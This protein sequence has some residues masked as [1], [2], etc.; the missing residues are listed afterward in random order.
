MPKLF[1]V[2]IVCITALLN[3]THSNAQ[4]R[5][6]LTV[7]YDDYPFNDACIPGDGFSCMITGIGQNL[8]FDTGGNAPVLL[9]NM[10]QL[11]MDPG[12]FDF[13]VI[14]HEHKDHTNGLLSIL[15]QNR[16]AAVFIPEG[17]SDFELLRQVQSLGNNTVLV[18][19]PTQICTGVFS[20][21]PMQGHGLF[22][23][24]LIINS[25]SGL[26][27]V[28]GC[29]HPGITNIIEKSIK[30]FRKRV[31]FVFGGFHLNSA[32]ES[33]I[34]D[35]VHKFLSLGVTGVGGSHCTGTLMMQKLM[36]VYGKNYVQMGAGRSIALR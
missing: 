8:L 36:A 9:H 10:K 30:L 31:L 28:C 25:K 14:S 23:Q 12:I 33:L 32:S 22:E 18:R 11:N 13:I 29:A 6:Q 24:S 26:V 16:K 15:E 34:N 20:T 4:S 2:F 5:A 17:F 35:T 19:Y 27:L 21:G 1:A 3:E 7:L